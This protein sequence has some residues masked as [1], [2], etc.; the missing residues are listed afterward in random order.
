MGITLINGIA[1]TAST[2]T[3][4]STA[5]SISV[6]NTP[7]GTGPYYL[8]F[9]DATSGYKTLLVD[10]STLTYNA[11]SNTLTA[12]TFAGTA[13]AATLVSLGVN[14]ANNATNYLIFSHQFNPGGL[15]M[16][17]VSESANVTFN[18]STTEFRAGLVNGQ[19]AGNKS[20]T[21]DA[22]LTVDAALT[23][24]VT[25]IA[26]LTATRS[27]VVNNLD[28][29]RSVIVYIRNTNATQRQIVFSGSATT[30]GQVGINMSIGAGIASVV[31][32]SIAGTSGTML[33]HLFNINNTLVGGIS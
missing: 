30:T 24:S 21:A 13:S 9:V 25:W 32:Q 17:S 16:S 3:S 10:D 7:T 27:L 33:V 5:N 4:S 28:N 2:S 22:S 23:Q 15:A 19:S 29:G 26:G 11:T 14:T 1:I 18:P 6:L 12:T 20:Y 31:T 8:T